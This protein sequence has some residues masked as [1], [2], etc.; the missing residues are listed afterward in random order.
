MTR[1]G[2]PSRIGLRVTPK[3]RVLIA[4]FTDVID[5]EVLTHEKL[6]PVLG[7]TTVADARAR[8]PRRPCGGADRWR[9]PLGGHPQR[10]R[11]GHHR[12]RRPG[13]GAARLGQRR[14]QH[15]QLRAGHQ[16]RAV[17]DDRHRLRRSQLA[18][19]RTCSPRTCMNWAR[20]A[21]N[22]DAG[23]TMPNFAGLSPW[24][25]PVR[26]RARRIRA[27]PTTRRAAAAAGARQP[28]RAAP[29]RRSR[30]RGAARR[31]ARAGGR[32][33]RTTDQ[34]VTRG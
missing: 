6:C 10:R 23:V 34:E 20:I 4:P 11:L 21:Y 24:R 17:D 7:M 13:A 25:S 22:A 15:R 18:S 3:T 5:E 31:A 9:R 8:H 32:R 29:R 19:A 1:R 30:H 12:I 33:T 28:A 27:R 2:S 14:Q 16:P 26:A